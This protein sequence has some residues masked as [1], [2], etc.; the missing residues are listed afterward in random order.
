MSTASRTFRSSLMTASSVSVSGCGSQVS[1]VSVSFQPQAAATVRLGF[2]VGAKAD[3]LGFLLGITGEWATVRD[4]TSATGYTVAAVRR[5]ADDMAAARFVHA[6][7]G[8]PAA[9]RADPRAWSQV[10]GFTSGPPAWRSW[11][12][13]F[14]FVA[15]FLA[16]EQEAQRKPLTPYVP[17]V[18]RP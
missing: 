16:W 2:G 3:V 4:T 1:S 15:A 6:T 14:A 10:L 9:V 17:G 8:Q 13:R 5:A 11:Q 12:Q 18:K 7:P